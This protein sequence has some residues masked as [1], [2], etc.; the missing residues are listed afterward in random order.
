MQNK[1]VARAALR[2]QLVLFLRGVA[3]FFDFLFSFLSE[4]GDVGL[5]DE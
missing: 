4:L 5:A 2:K 1:N 3:R